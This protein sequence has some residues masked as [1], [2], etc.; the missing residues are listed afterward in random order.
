MGLWG[1]PGAGKAVRVRFWGS[2][3]CAG[4]AKS[5]G[6]RA[7]KWLFWNS[8]VKNVK[9]RRV[10]AVGEVSTVCLGMT[11]KVGPGGGVKTSR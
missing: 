11:G 3:I 10:G 9:L 6:L 5:A 4:V 8:E 2:P 1:P 7:S